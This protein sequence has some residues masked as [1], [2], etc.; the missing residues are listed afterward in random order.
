MNFF[1]IEEF[2]TC[3]CHSSITKMNCDYANAKLQEWLKDA[4]VVYGKYAK[5]NGHGLSLSE[6]REPED[7]HKALIIN[8][9]PIEQCK[10]VGEFIYTKITNDGPEYLLAHCRNCLSKFKLV[11]HK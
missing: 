7:T 9:E 11:E 3:H 5:I 2:A 4:K 6:K 8:I 1:K 10:H